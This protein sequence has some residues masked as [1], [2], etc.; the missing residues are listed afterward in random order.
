VSR[1]HDALKRAEEKSFANLS[2]ATPA[3][4]ERATLPFSEMIEALELAAPAASAAGSNMVAAATLPTTSL[5][6]QNCTK[7]VWTP[8][9]E[10]LFLTAEDSSAPG[11]EEF[12]TLRSK[13]FQI[14][15]KRP[16]KTILVS[17][18]VPG[19][20][21]SFVC[22]N[23]AQAFARQ[24]GGR[25]LLIDADMR[26]PQLHEVFGAPSSPGL[27]E[28]LSGTAS[29]AEVVQRSALSEELFFLPAGDITGNAAELIGT[30]RVKALLDKL[31]PLFNWIVIDSSPVGPVS[32]ATRL[33]E[34]CDG[35]LMVV[36]AEGTSHIA[37]EHAK[38]EFNPASL[39]GVVFNRTSKKSRPGYNYK[40]NYRPNA[41]KPGNRE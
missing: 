40:Y 1:I 26:R 35:V 8:S 16:L 25:T 14:R 22:A 4:E 18:A 20:G 41:G 29:A 30:D 11:L 21:K 9:K 6:I 27:F 37:A 23:L 7:T 19:E 15:A 32:D 17:S 28:Y 31:T 5:S 13:L 39:L 12:R 3:V 38:R 33:A 34:L 24:N 36:K 10:A 2:P